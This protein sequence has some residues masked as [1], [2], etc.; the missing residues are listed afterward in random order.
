M[1]VNTRLVIQLVII[2]MSLLIVGYVSYKKN[3]PRVTFPTDGKIRYLVLRKEYLDEQNLTVLVHCY[4]MDLES[5][6]LTYEPVIFSKYFFAYANSISD[7]TVS[8]MRIHF[9]SDVDDFCSAPY[10]YDE[11]NFDDVNLKKVYSFYVGRD[12]APEFIVLKAKRKTP[13]G[14]IEFKVPEHILNS[15][16][17]SSKYE[18]INLQSWRQIKAL[19]KEEWR[20][21]NNE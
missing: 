12:S 7:R 3:L 17:D 10:Y 13:E 6:Q 15:P 9:L 2:S 1:K 11:V 14:E 18:Q 19:A 21:Y 4:N 16:V 20:K 5:E 8:R